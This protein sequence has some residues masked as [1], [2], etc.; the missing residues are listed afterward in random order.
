MSKH[1]L[2]V[3]TQKRVITI[4]V[5]A[6]MLLQVLVVPTSSNASEIG[7][8]YDTAQELDTFFQSVNQRND[9]VNETVMED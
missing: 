4:S 8:N 1:T 3:L 6:L 7:T 9:K 2:K 5:V